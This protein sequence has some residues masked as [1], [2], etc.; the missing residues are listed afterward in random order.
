MENVQ[1]ENYQNQFFPFFHFS[2]LA[3]L[4]IMVLLVDV[5]QYS[6]M[7]AGDFITIPVGKAFLH[8]F[9]N[10]KMFSRIGNIR[11]ML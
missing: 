5:F 2:H 4:D 10:K 7:L 6:E 3:Y 8:T 1:A 11:F 9:L